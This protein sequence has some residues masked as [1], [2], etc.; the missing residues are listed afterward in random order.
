MLLSN[1]L[2]VLLILIAGTNA[3][4]D[5]GYEAKVVARRLWRYEKVMDKAR[6]SLM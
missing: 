5:A 1:A 2:S 3:A 4:K 6:K